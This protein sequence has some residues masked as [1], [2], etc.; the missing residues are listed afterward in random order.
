MS[1]ED[2]ASQSSVV[3]ET[4]FYN[5][6]EKTI[7]EV[8][9]H[10]SS[11]SAQTLVMRSVITNHHLIAHCL[12]NIC[13]KNYQ[14]RLMCVEVRVCNISVIFLDTMHSLNVCCM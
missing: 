9:V 11:D 13:A 2:V 4:W 1:V 7:S 14:N 3:F 5:M 10:V 8:H 12:S 6:T